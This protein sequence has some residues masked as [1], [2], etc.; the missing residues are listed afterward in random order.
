MLDE[1]EHNGVI[2]LLRSAAESR[3]RFLL[4]SLARFVAR[5]TDANGSSAHDGLLGERIDVFHRFE[6]SEVALADFLSCGPIDE[7]FSQA[8]LGFVRP[9]WSSRRTAAPGSSSSTH[10]HWA[11]PQSQNG[12]TPQGGSG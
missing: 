9:T 1:P 3:F 5:P 4:R 10:H 6:R 11:Q 8:A 7:P 12:N 2:L